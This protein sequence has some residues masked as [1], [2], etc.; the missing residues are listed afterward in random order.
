MGKAGA[1]I[2]ASIGGLIGLIIGAV[3]PSEGE[4]ALSFFSRITGNM[5]LNDPV[6]LLMSTVYV[7]IAMSIC[8]LIGGIIGGVFR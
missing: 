7:I 4:I 1:G 5:I 2:G 3:I 8:S 6:G